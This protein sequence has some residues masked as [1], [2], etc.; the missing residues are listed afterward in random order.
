VPRSTFHHRLLTNLGCRGVI[1]RKALPLS[2]QLGRNTSHSRSA[3]RVDTGIAVWLRSGR[4]A[5]R[6]LSTRAFGRGGPIWGYH[7]VMPDDSRKAQGNHHIASSQP[8]GRWVA[9]AALVIAV[10]AVGVAI[11]ALVRSPGEA[12]ATSGE[13]AVSAQQPDDAKTHVC[14]AFDVVRK[15]VSRQT[16]TDLGSDPVAKETVAANARLATLGGG[17]YLLSRLDSATPPELADAVRLFATNL[18]DIGMN[19]L[20]GVP[21]TD[22]AVAAR[23]SEVQAASPQITE[24][25]T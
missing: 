16:N 9:P 7:R 15:A 3:T 20:A 8:A 12:A 19:Q 14:A 25:C 18:Q 5:L 17:E 21:N 1:P 6:P 23:L 10:I 11:W 24:M 2:N 22:P 13:P 4:E